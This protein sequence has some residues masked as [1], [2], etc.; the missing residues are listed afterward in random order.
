M[1]KMT[2]HAVNSDFVTV[3]VAQR[4]GTEPPCADGWDVQ[5]SGAKVCAAV[6]DGAGH[7]EAVVRYAAIAPAVMTHMECP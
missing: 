4:P 6:V 5:R 3:G 1:T 2:K 7:H